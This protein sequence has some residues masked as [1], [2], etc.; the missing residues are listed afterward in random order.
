VLRLRPTAGCLEPLPG[1]QQR[2]LLSALLAVCS[3][4]LSS[5]VAPSE[6]SVFL[7]A[8]IVKSPEPKTTRWFHFTAGDQSY[9]YEN[10][11]EST[12]KNLACGQ[13]LLVCPTFRA[14]VFYR[15]CPMNDRCSGL[16]EQSF[17]QNED[18]RDRLHLTTHMC[19]M[20]V[21]G[22]HFRCL[23]TTIS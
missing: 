1:I 4:S 2:R 13:G 9:D 17:V 22:V 3:S 10:W 19:C 12:T 8:D 5:H 14:L 7:F 23:V 15:A 21:Y 11:L 6:E 18:H 16:A 20:H